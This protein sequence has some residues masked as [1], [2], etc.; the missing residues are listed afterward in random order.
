MIILIKIRLAGV[1]N[2]TFNVAIVQ[3]IVHIG[4]S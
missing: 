4:V 3:K 2:L 1:V